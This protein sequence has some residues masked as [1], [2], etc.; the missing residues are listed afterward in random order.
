MQYP[1]SPFGGEVRHS[2]KPNKQN[3]KTR[4]T[5]MSFKKPTTNQH[6]APNLIRIILIFHNSLLIV[7]I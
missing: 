1:D 7:K 2:K 6:S 4:I 5:K 3:E